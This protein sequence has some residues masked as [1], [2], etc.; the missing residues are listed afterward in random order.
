MAAE[1]AE[2]TVAKSPPKKKRKD[3][4]EKVEKAKGSKD[5]DKDVPKSMSITAFTKTSKKAAK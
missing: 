2:S 3:K 4:A 5:K 1:D